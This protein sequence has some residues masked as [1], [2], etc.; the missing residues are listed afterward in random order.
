MTH[1]TD[2]ISAG[3][4]DPSSPV[5]KKRKISRW[6]HKFRAVI[7][8][9][10]VLLL[11][12]TLLAA[13][14][15]ASAQNL[16]QQALSGKQYFELAQRSIEEQDF[17]NATIYL[18]KARQDFE[19]AQ[20]N[21]RNLEGVKF[22][23]FL[24]RQ[25]NAVDHILLAGIQASKAAEKVTNI[26]QL[27]LE[28]S[29]R[30]GN[31]TLSSITTEERREML[32]VLYESLPD[33]Q[34][35]RADIGLAV[36]SMN[37]IPELGLLG[38]V[39]EAVVP[40]KEKL[41]QIQGII[42][43]LVPLAE[44]LPQIVGYPNNK[45]YLFLLQNNQ[46]MRA[47]GGFIGTYGIL[48]LQDG[49]ISTF[50]TDNVYNLDEPVKDE[51]DKEPPA[52]FKKYIPSSIWFFRDCNWS[53]DFPETARTCLQFYEEENGP[54][55]TID[56]VIAITP[57]FIESLLELVG[58]IKVDG[59]LFTSE[60][61]TD[62]LQEEVEVTYRQ[63]G[64]SDADR[65]EI[66]GDLAD[67]LMSRLLTLPKER[68]K[69][70]WTTLQNNF[71]EK[72]VLI[73]LSNGELQSLVERENWDGSVREWNGDYVMV[74][75][76]N[77]ASLKSDPGVK[78]TI[79]YDLEVNRNQ[80]VIGNLTIHYSNQGTFSWK[81]TRYRTWVR[82][83]VPEGSQLLSYE[84]A[85]ENDKLAGGLPGQVEVHNELGKTQFGAFIA[86]EPKQEGTLKLRYRLPDSVL[87]NIRDGNYH[88]LVQKQSGTID[89]G[90]IVDLDFERKIRSYGSS[91]LKPE[92]YDNYIIY[93]TDLRQDRQFEIGL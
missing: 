14:N 46:E 3:K 18:Q 72:H 27:M 42:D 11:A 51:R 29:E 5:K 91:D 60:N 37:Q 47:T 84:G 80:E 74:T 87:Q 35:A 45:T 44:A 76:S 23:P 81:S 70:L 36:S 63:K 21:L 48:K 62:V 43:E 59:I 77:M 65:K 54:E 13:R 9:V 79:T 73:N 10:I 25:I 19:L 64:I 32:R 22:V 52:P 86:I 8:I 56:G 31:T 89:H 57:T 2:F 41:P 61:V 16:Y 85:M 33:L 7:Y 39:K 69:D 83:Y 26:A 6:F 71:A 82:V 20:T 50:V 30:S 40:L 55:K 34:A 78:R 12:G 68:W 17:V 4:K 28:Q 38:S 58:D 53:P 93:H 49:D 24:I 1:S 15:Y 75:D 66:V 92:V 67:E 90:L 88:L